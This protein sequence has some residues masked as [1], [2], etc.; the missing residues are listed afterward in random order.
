[1][2][3]DDGEGAF[4]SMPALRPGESLVRRGLVTLADDSGV[5]LGIMVVTDQRV[6]VATTEATGTELVFSA[7]SADLELGWRVDG[8]AVKEF[9][10]AAGTKG[11]ARQMIAVRRHPD[12]PEDAVALFEA[13][14]GG[15]LPDPPELPGATPPG[16]ALRWWR[17]LTARR[18]RHW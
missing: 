10:V 11:P 6:M 8:G 7:A 9:A 17:W 2:N 3:H 5:N 4:A 14:H 15:P 1:M 12:A 13:I 18:R 16:R